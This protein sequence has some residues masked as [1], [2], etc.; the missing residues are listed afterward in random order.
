[1]RYKLLGNTGLRVSELCLGAM[2]FGDERGADRDEADRIVRAFADG[3]GN[4]ID[5]ADAY[6]HGTSERLVGELIGADRDRW[7]VATKYTT[8]RDPADPNAAGNHRKNLARALDASLERLGTDHVDLLWIHIWDF[9]TPVEE[10]MRA[11][12]DQVRA[13]RVHYLG[14]SDTPAWVVARANTIAEQR[15]WTP[16]S[17]IQA[18]YSL[19]ER[20]PERDLTPMAAA[21][22]L[23]VTAWAPLGSGFLSGRHD[24]RGASR[25]S[26]R[27]LAIS[28]VVHEV[29]EE[30]GATPAQVA[31][32]WLRSRPGTVIPIAGV[33][34]EAQIVDNLG[35]LA[36]ALDADQRARLDDVSS[37]D[38]GFPHDF[39][40]RVL[41]TPFVLGDD[42]DRID[43]HR[44]VPG[45]RT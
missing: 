40:E 44:T 2:T 29:A 36:L 43:N 39:I 4:F 32:A 25:V 31:L 5:T 11:L 15:G 27:N 33:S 24:G 7:V 30:A 17:A 20:T 14:I 3:G 37:I 8:S 41:H 38:L 35:A 1:M 23:A 16:F 18:Q 34:K 9:M 13:G 42:V 10:V 6:G 21:L 19:V 28:R 12:D 22:D 26:D 45:L